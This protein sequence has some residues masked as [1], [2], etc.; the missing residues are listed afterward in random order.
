VD[1]ADTKQSTFL[2]H[3]EPLGEIQR[4]VVA[5][6]S[7]DAAVAEVLGDVDRLVIRQAERNRGAA[8]AEA[9]RVANTEKLQPGNG[10]QAV[11]ELRE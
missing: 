10:E 11:D 4:V 7:E 2:F 1:D 5:V 8:L 6:P 9:L 3:A